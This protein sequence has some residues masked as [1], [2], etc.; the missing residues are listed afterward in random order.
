MF[1]GGYEYN[2]ADKGRVIIPKDFRDDLTGTFVITKGLGRCLFIIPE[3][4]WVN[5]FFNK[6]SAR[7]VLDADSIVLSRRFIGSAV[8]TSVDNQ[9]RIAVPELLRNF[10]GIEP[11]KPVVLLGVANHVEM[12]SKERL[13]AYDDALTDDAIISAANNTGIGQGILS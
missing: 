13:D 1:S 7:P 11:Q 12:W 10:A 3:K 6:F 2:I 9:G 8:K 4:E 5:G